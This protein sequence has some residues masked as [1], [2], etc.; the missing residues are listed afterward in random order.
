MLQP[1]V[2]RTWARR[3]C[4]P[5]LPVCARYDRLSVISAVTLSPKRQRFGFYFQVHPNN[6]RTGEVVAFVRHLQRHLKN[7]LQL[8]WDGASI[9][10][11]AEK[12]LCQSSDAVRVEYLPPYSP[13]LNPVERAWAHTKHGDLANFAPK[14]IDCLRVAVNRSLD[15]KRRHQALLRGFFRGS[16]L[17]L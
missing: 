15:R 6:I 8:V 5:I 12:R 3:G 11:A 4:T 9:H 17:C 7:K 13:E 2:R 10:K 14:D 16:Q 1:T